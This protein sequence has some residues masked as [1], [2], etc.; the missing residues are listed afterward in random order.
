MPGVRSQGLSLAWAW[1]IREFTWPLC[2][3]KGQV[4]HTGLPSDT[5][6]QYGPGGVTPAGIA[7]PHLEGLGCSGHNDSA[8]P[9]GG[10]GSISILWAGKLT[11]RGNETYPRSHSTSAEVLGQSSGKGGPEVQFP[12]S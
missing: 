11:Q 9:L 8:L 3:W 7:M 5:P 2:C 12:L 6:A 1:N 4:G 10:T